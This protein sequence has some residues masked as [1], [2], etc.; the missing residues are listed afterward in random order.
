[1]AASSHVSNEG[2]SPTGSAE[3]TIHVATAPAR[4][5]DSDDEDNPLE[6][7]ES[8]ERAEP[9]HVDVDNE[10]PAYEGKGKGRMLDPPADA[11]VVDRADNAD[12]TNNAHEG[13]DVEEYNLGPEDDVKPDEMNGSDEDARSHISLS[14]DDDHKME[15]AA[16]DDM[17]W[18]QMAPAERLRYEEMFCAIVTRPMSGSWSFT[19][20][21]QMQLDKQMTAYINDFPLPRWIVP[22]ATRIPAFE[23][24]MQRMVWRANGNKI[25]GPHGVA[26]SRPQHPQDRHHANGQ[27][28]V[29]RHD[30]HTGMPAHRS[31]PMAPP[32]T[33][34]SQPHEQPIPVPPGMA[35]GQP[36]RPPMSHN[37]HQRHPNGNMGPPAGV[38][39]GNA[40]PTPSQFPHGRHMQ[41]V[42]GSVYPPGF[43]TNP[44]HD[45]ATGKKLKLTVRNGY[46]HSPAAEPPVEAPTPPYPVREKPESRKN[47]IKGGRGKMRRHAE[48]DVFPWNRQ[49][50][51][52]EKAKVAAK[53]SE[54]WDDSIYP[55]ETLEQMAAVRVRN[56]PF[57]AKLEDHIT[58]KQR[59]SR[60]A[61]KKAAQSTDLSSDFDGDGGER[62]KGGRKKM[63]FSEDRSDPYH[64]GN[65]AFASAEDQ[66]LAST[67]G[68]RTPDELIQA[69]EADE[70]PLDEL[71]RIKI[72]WSPG[73]K[74]NS[75]ELQQGIFSVRDTV[76]TRKKLDETPILNHRAAEC[77][78]DF[79][80]DLLWRDVLL[81]MLSEGNFSNKEIRD[82]FCLNGCFSDRATVAKRLGAALGKDTNPPGKKGDDPRDYCEINRDDFDMYQAFFGKRPPARRVIK[83][84]RKDDSEDVSSPPVKKQKTSH[85]K[86][87]FKMEEETSTSPSLGSAKPEDKDEDAVSIQDS[88]ELDAMSD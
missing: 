2:L 72:C 67:M 76:I 78:I 51:D 54:I 21:Y 19:E 73:K 44:I 14:S 39:M 49:D 65:F 83:Q 25:Y 50:I 48:T 87:T 74:G 45:A 1:M 47:P 33:L 79:C 53:S 57:I 60:H 59:I 29:A 40:R 5:V 46:G 62:K 26:A 86:V 55:K 9:H 6:N 18:R 85:K 34:R 37:P 70:I 11:S 42:Q 63:E 36:M 81:R 43:S 41:Q 8:V 69:G 17:P 30:P 80:P 88:D 56:E 32:Q 75:Q 27:Q 58:E 10:L 84:H 16:I 38:L 15:V 52:F 68:K 3:D 12:D 66:Q 31:Q 23:R 13:D 28:M 24:M 64:S 22:A 7:L 82:R 61:K 4:D 20:E 71:A 77:I 35:N